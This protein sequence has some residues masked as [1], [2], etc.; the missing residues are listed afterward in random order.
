[1]PRFTI[2]AAQVAAVHGDLDRN[3]RTHAAAIEAAARLGVAVLVFPELSL[4]GYEPETAAS[5]AVAPD[6]PRLAGLR[7]LALQHA[8]HVAAGA[9]LINGY[10]KPHLGAILYGP[11]GSTRTYAKMHL[12]GKEPDFFSPGLAPVVFESGGETIGLS[13][14]ADSSRPSHPE[15]CAAL[16]ATVYAA[17]MFLN[18]AWF[19]TDAPRLEAYASRHRLLV[20]M[21]NHAASTGPFESVGRSAAWS[22]VGRLLAQCR[23]TEDALVIAT[24]DASGW[25]GSATE[26]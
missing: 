7:T 13:I 3:L 8:M 14:C 11:D 2:A 24:L 23:G 20:L 12:G 16:G 25:S 22:P 26:L 21:A 1:M 5:L 19:A 17:G 6:D 4:V 18:A 9:P 15:R 10:G